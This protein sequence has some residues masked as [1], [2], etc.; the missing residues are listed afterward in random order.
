MKYYHAF[1]SGM[2]SYEISYFES[3]LKVAE[4]DF[5]YLNFYCDVIFTSV[6][7]LFHKHHLYKHREPQIWPKT[8][9][10]LRTSLSL[11]SL[12]HT[13][14]FKQIISIIQLSLFS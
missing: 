6:H 8:K 13:N 12:Q 7:A 1:L 10:H 14:L 2:W 9:H 5:D 3:Q 4:S 11:T